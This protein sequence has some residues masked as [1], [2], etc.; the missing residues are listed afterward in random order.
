M[1]EKE[2]GITKEEAIEMLKSCND[3]NQWS[4]IVYEI[5]SRCYEKKI[6]ILSMEDARN[7]ANAR[8]DEICAELLVKDSTDKLIRLRRGEDYPDK[9]VK[10]TASEYLIM[11]KLVAKYGTLYDARMSDE[12]GKL[13]YGDIEMRKDET[14]KTYDMF[15]MRER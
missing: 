7:L 11:A 5:K 3:L 12:E 13:I 10:V 4:D 15:Y 8:L 6:A 1:T 14:P 2:I 9:I